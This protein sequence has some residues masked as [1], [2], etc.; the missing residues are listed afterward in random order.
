[1]NWILGRQPEA[2][3]NYSIIYKGKSG[4][5]SAMSS[6]HYSKKLDAWNVYDYDSK[7]KGLEAKH[8]I[9]VLAY[10]DGN[11]EKELVREVLGND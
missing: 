11:Y 5:K 7:D 9:E 10:A 3:G 1:M 4:F 6:V 8:D 2:S